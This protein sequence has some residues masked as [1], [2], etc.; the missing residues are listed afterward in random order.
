MFEVNDEGHRD[1]SWISSKLNHR[2]VLY[3][4]QVSLFLTLYIFDTFFYIPS[5]DF[6]LYYLPVAFSALCW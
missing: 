4:V 6:S 1:M 3:V 2:N 5:I